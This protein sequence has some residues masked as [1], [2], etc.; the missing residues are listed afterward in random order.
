M[1]TKQCSVSSKTPKKI[2]LLFGIVMGLYFPIQALGVANKY[3]GEYETKN[4]TYPNV[5]YTMANCPYRDSKK[6]ANSAWVGGSRTEYT[7]MGKYEG[8]IAY[9]F[10]NEEEAKTKSKYFSIN[11]EGEE[12][13]RNFTLKASSA[14]WFCAVT[15]QYVAGVVDA[16]NSVFIADTSKYGMHRWGDIFP[17]TPYSGII[18]KVDCINAGLELNA[19][20][21]KPIINLNPPDTYEK[22][23]NPSNGVIS[24]S[25]ITNL[26]TK[27]S[28][29]KYSVWVMDTLDKASKP[30]PMGGDFPA[31]FIRNG[32]GLFVEIY[33]KWRGK[34]F[35]IKAER[36]NKPGFNDGVNPDP[37]KALTQFSE[38]VALGDMCNP[39]EVV[40]NNSCIKPT[41]AMKPLI[42]IT[43]DNAAVGGNK[44]VHVA[45]MEL[46]G[47]YY[48]CIM[49]GENVNNCKEIN[50][51]IDA[52]EA[53]FPIG[54]ELNGKQLVV[55]LVQNRGSMDN[56]VKLEDYS[57]KILLEDTVTNN[58]TYTNI[59]HSKEGTLCYPY[60]PCTITNSFKS[61]SFI[62]NE[63][64][65]GEGIVELLFERGDPS[66]NRSI[67]VLNY[68]RKPLSASDDSTGES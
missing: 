31:V 8:K 22:D 10:K 36:V 59:V 51:R 60:P 57:N 5:W 15:D 68:Q 30:Y 44:L 21:K 24:H 55:K 53:E 50:G 9:S 48:S 3:N 16:N 12:S 61:A 26:E 43:K 65:H 62:P 67:E 45:N 4:N 49:D 25:R 52:H 14:K 37:N 64:S 39:G 18:V 1:K 34:Y 33:P 13:I 23:E 56:K 19:T 58:C 42:K 20:L 46:S 41:I 54:S 66:L 7:N 27:G 17:S 29:V 35:A 2:I 6:V 63:G 47:T 28:Q 11:C 40:E 38:W 32:G